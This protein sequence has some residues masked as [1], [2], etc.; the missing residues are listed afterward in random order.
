MV[1]TRQ[2]LIERRDAL[3]RER[4]EEITLDALTRDFTIYQRRRGHRHSTDDLL[5]AWYAVMHAPPSP[6][7]LLDL[8]SGIGSVGLSVLWRFPEATLT[9]I[10]VQPVSF[11]LLREN[12]SA[13]SLEERVTTICGD[14]RQFSARER[15]DLVTGSP[16]YFDVTDGIVSADPQRAAARFELHGTVN[17][18]C[19]AAASALTDGGR[20]VFCFPTLQTERAK[21][22]CANAEL[23]ILTLRDVIPKVALPPLFSLFACAKKSDALATTTRVEPP[24]IVRDVNGEHT[25]EMHAVREGFGFTPGVP[26]IV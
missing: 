12:V 16:P 1:R 17:D 20:F 21:A 8:G 25:P 10:E 26:H 3:T 13:S 14:L 22:A 5:T 18:Y 19:V 24:L 4:G 6:R 7:H 23:H 11:A 9:A 15:Y 2:E